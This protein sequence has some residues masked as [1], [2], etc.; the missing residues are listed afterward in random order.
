MAFPRG[1]SQVEEGIRT[2]RINGYK[3]IQSL[4]LRLD[5]KRELSGNANSVGKE[6]K[7]NNQTNHSSLCSMS[8]QIASMFK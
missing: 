1:H 5:C 2:K 8:G 7:L 4:D 6:S 3:E